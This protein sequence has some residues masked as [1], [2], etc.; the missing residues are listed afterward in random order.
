MILRFIPDRPGLRQ[1]EF[2]CLFLLS[3]CLFLSAGAK[4]QS[5][6]SVGPGGGD[7]RALA[8]DP[9]HAELVYLGTTDGH[10]F[11]SRD[12]GEHWNLLGMAGSG[13][14]AIV[15]AILVDPRGAGVLFAGTWTRESHGEGG[16]FFSASTAEN[17]GVNRT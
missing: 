12:A 10:I 3:C 7:V 6:R 11:G 8:V 9:A 17:P 5:W 14:N 4:A 2:Y 15:T 1:P 16:E 13:S